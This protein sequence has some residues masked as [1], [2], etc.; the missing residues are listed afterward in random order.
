MELCLTSLI[1]L[2]QP[3]YMERSRKK[4]ATHYCRFLEHYLA[5]LPFCRGKLH[6]AQ[7]TRH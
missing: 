4:G 7:A 1:K 3:D 5:R 2:A 6:L